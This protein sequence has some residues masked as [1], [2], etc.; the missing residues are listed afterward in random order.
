M[1]WFTRLL[2]GDERDHRLIKIIPPP[3]FK[4][5]PVR[6]KQPSYTEYQHALGLQRQMMQAQLGMYGPQR[7]LGMAGML[8]GSSIGNLAGL[9]GRQRF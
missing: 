2:W 6:I 9:L 1:N 7:G 3:S 4:S 8:A 5:E